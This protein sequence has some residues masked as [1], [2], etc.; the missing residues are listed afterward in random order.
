[1]QAQKG[2]ANGAVVRNNSID[3][4]IVDLLAFDGYTKAFLLQPRGEAINDD[5][6][7]LF[8]P[9]YGADLFPSE[10][11]LWVMGTSGTT[12]TPKLISH[13]FASLTATTKANLSVGARHR[14]G[15]LYDPARFAGLQV[16]LQA[17]VS[18]GVLVAPGLEHSLDDAIKFMADSGVTSLS[19]TPSYWRKILM[20][21]TVEQLELRQ[22]TLGGE[23]AE[24]V[25]LSALR[26]KFPNGRIVHIY[27][28]TEAG[29]GFSVSDGREGFPV[30]YL[31]E[32]VLN[33]IQL[34][35]RDDGHL[36]IRKTHGSQHKTDTEYFDTEDLIEIQF[37][38]VVFLG[39]AGG[40]IN[41]GGNKVTPE[42]IEAI[43]G[44]HPRVIA[45]RV[46]GKKNSLMG[47]LVIAEVQIETSSDNVA[48][49]KEL[50]KLCLCHL[51]RWQCPV[52]IRVVEKIDLAASGK[53]SRKQTN[54]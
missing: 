24:Q 36:L 37:D 34:K 3:E 44:S 42:K 20:S 19:A 48:I 6:G 35:M 11:T 46:F 31:T 4:F 29:V 18:G 32:G 16:V 27:A 30:D 45:A 50:N 38:R 8:R 52:S 41:V 28:S 2:S 10:M 15:L 7:H 49:V 1:M 14:W 53:L 40:A 33:G 12:G 25:I 9:T 13:N 17:L 54:G 39:R 47:N 22:L 23:I 43:L 26:H 5:W 21:P 51:E